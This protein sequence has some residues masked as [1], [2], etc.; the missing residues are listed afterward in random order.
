M[1]KS[2]NDII[3]TASQESLSDFC[4]KASKV[5]RLTNEEIAEIIPDGIEHKRFAEL[6]QIVNDTSASNQEKADKI[7]NVAGYAEI[8]A[9]LLTKLI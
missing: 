1:K 2:L 3:E 4:N 8:V 7:R 5:V 9:N 6:I